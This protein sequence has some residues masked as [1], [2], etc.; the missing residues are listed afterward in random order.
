MKLSICQE[1]GPKVNILILLWY[2][3]PYGKHMNIKQ[4]T[5]EHKQ[6]CVSDKTFI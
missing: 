4:S 5:C 1:D 2:D 6:I 3:S